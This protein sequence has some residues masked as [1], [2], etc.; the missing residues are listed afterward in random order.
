MQDPKKNFN[1]PSILS[2]C[3]GVLGLLDICETWNFCKIKKGQDPIIISEMW[4]EASY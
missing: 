1:Q 4:I 3:E 2:V